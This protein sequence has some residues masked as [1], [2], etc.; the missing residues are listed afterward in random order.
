MLEMVNINVG[1]VLKNLNLTVEKNEFV[2]ILG[3]NG[4]GK[5]TLFNTI[6]GGVRPRSGVVR[7]DGADVSNAPQWVRASLVSN[8]FQDPKVG[9][10]G[11]MTIR[12]NLNLAYTR[13]KA[14]RFVIG[15]S[16]ERDDLF[17]EK[18]GVL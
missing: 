4:A 1:N 5:T 6:S 11:N 12:E 15:G 2:L 9:T 13:G 14:R 17:K 8:V 7:I 18:L 10:V 16:R 3:E